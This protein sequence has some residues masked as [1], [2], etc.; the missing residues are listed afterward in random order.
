[1]LTSSISMFMCMKMD[2][3]PLNVFFFPFFLGHSQRSVQRG[4]SRQEG[5]KP[6]F[7]GR[8]QECIEQPDRV[9]T[10]LEPQNP[11]IDVSER[12]KIC[13]LALKL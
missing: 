11:L 9:F 5:V 4:L 6:A 13:L 2:S 3:T 8:S 10:I 12:H 7:V 1:M